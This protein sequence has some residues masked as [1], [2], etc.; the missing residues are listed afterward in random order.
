[1]ILQKIKVSFCDTICYLY[2]ILNNTIYK[3]LNIRKIKLL[4]KKRRCYD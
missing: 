1:M 2:I 4:D 3:I